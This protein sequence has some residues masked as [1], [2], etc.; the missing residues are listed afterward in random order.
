LSAVV[1]TSALI[2]LAR[3]HLLKLLPLLFGD[4]YVPQ[5]V[6]DEWSEGSSNTPEEVAAAAGLPK[7]WLQIRPVDVLEDAAGANLGRG[8]EEVIVLARQLG[9]EYVVLDDLVARRVALSRGLRV[10]GTVG[11]LMAARRTGAI[12][13]VV[14]LLENLREAGF[15]LSDEVLDAVR[16]D[17]EGTTS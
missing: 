1:D 9:A 12:P 3:L 17:E 5:A 6:L 13:S 15:R 16:R 7:G 14:R 11:V 4:V 2:T 8:E 10:I